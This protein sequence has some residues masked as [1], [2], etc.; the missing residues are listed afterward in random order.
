MTG[1]EKILKG[2]QRIVSREEKILQLLFPCFFLTI[3]IMIDFL[4]ISSPFDQKRKGKAF[5]FEIKREMKPQRK[6][7][8]LIFPSSFSEIQSFA[9]RSSVGAFPSTS[10][11]WP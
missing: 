8:T 9:A 2:A 5:H 11:K 3:F 6:D 10:V 1:D 4:T 7:K